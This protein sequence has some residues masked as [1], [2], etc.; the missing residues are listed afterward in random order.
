MAPQ[1]GQLVACWSSLAEQAG[2]LL[3]I[4]GSFIGALPWGACWDTIDD[5]WSSGIRR[6]PTGDTSCSAG[7]RSCGLLS[8]SGGARLLPDGH[9]A[10]HGQATWSMRRGEATRRWRVEVAGGGVSADDLERGEP[11]ASRQQSRPTNQAAMDAKLASL[12]Q[13]IDGP[14]ARRAGP[15]GGRPSR[16]ARPGAPPPVPS[17]TW[18]GAGRRPTRHPAGAAADPGAHGPRRAA[19]H[20]HRRRPRPD[21][22]H[23]APEVHAADLPRRPSHPATRTN[24]PASAPTPWTCV[25]R[26]RSPCAPTSPSCCTV[27]GPACRCCPAATSTTGWTRR[28][29]RS[30]RARPARSWRRPGSASR[31]GRRAAPVEPGGAHPGRAAVQSG[32]SGRRELIDHVFA[33][34]MLLSPLPEMTTAAAGPA[35]LRSPR[36]R[37]RRSA[38]PAPTMPRWWPA[39]SCPAEPRIVGGRTW[40]LVLGTV[41]PLVTVKLSRCEDAYPSIKAGQRAAA[42][43]C[44]P[45]P[46]GRRLLAV[47]GGAILAAQGSL[48]AAAGLGRPATV[49]T[50]QR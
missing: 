39:S 28:P 16:A 14:P 40:R 45:R 38:R 33:S 17:R 10:R 47:L 12:A 13:V 20:R 1:L 19:G 3:D 4:D 49:I 31:P 21:D 9:P 15:A 8:S 5:R 18:V 42:F 25:L 43:G 37:P 36:T 22:H 35:T 2:H 26:R 48:V 44:R 34:R 6:R 7:R 29:P 23:R 27:L 50:G 41:A 24:A 30:C 32:V 46:P 11:V